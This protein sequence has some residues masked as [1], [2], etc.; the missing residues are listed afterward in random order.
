MT[1]TNL[2]LLLIYPIFIS[3]KVQSHPLSAC[4]LMISATCV[5]LKLSSFHHVM[6]DNRSMLKKMAAK[7]TIDPNDNQSGLPNDVYKESLKYPNTLEIK[8]FVRYLCAPTCCY[9]LLYPT[10]SKIRKSFLLKRFLEILFCNI[11]I[12]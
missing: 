9:Q 10:T 1:L 12:V 8:R 3:F 5:L 6:F 7:G 4:Y 2:I 11:F